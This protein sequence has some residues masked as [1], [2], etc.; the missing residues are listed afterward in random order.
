MGFTMYGVER[1]AYLVDSRLYDSELMVLD[2]D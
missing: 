1:R 2:L